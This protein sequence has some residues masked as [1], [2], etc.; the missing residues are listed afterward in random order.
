MTRN[1]EWVASTFIQVTAWFINHDIRIIG[2][3][4]KVGE[5]FIT[6]SENLSSEDQPCTGS[7]L[8]IGCKSNVHYQSLLPIEMN[9]ERSRNI[10]S[11]QNLIETPRNSADNRYCSSLLSTRT[12][13]EG[14]TTS[15]HRKSEQKPKSNE[16]SASNQNTSAI[17]AFSYQIGKKN[18]MSILLK[19]LQEYPISYSEK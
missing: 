1:Y 4:A 17:K 16:I 15:K 18:S 3:T 14:Y 7:P 11:T 19:K 6:V 12:Y 10:T 8:I 2:T 13:T 9:P 5:P